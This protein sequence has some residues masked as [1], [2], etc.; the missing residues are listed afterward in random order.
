MAFPIDGCL[1]F[2]CACSYSVVKSNTTFDWK[3]TMKTARQLHSWFLFVYGL[4]VICMDFRFFISRIFFIALVLFVLVDWWLRS[5]V[6]RA[7][8]LQS[9]GSRCFTHILF[10]FVFSRPKEM[11]FSI[12]IFHACPHFLKITVIY[13]NSCVLIWFTANE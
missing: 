3:W 6:H 9:C 11:L 4:S 13:V 12:Y 8:A 7:Y 2:L 1:S 10:Y 5:T